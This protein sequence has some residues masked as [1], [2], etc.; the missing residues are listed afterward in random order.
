ML[1]IFQRM[2]L[3]SRR[4][5]FYFYLFLYFI[6]SEQAFNSNVQLLKR[7]RNFTTIGNKLFV[8]SDDNTLRVLDV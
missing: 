3:K 4:K 1:K 2:V 5:L 6:F 8:G 7:Y